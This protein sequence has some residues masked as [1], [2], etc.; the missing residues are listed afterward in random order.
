MSKSPN[1][2]RFRNT[3]GD[4]S[5]NLTPSSVGASKWG[6]SQKSYIATKVSNRTVG[7][8]S[9]LNTANNQNVNTMNIQNHQQNF[10]TLSRNDDD[11][12]DKYNAT[13][14]LF[15]KHQRS[16]QTRDAEL[17]QALEEDSQ[18]N[19]IESE[20]NIRRKVSNDREVKEKSNEFQKLKYENSQLLIQN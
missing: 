7:H 17:E 14:M 1:V 6:L 5:L 4:E 11:E 18:S 10:T 13:Q 9:T 12:A 2:Q 19:T 3:D 15:G 16:L 20:E 8:A